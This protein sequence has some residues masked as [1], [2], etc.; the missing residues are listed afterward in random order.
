VTAEDAVT[1]LAGLP[2]HDGAAR[3]YQEIGLLE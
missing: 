3:Y 1:D 2:I